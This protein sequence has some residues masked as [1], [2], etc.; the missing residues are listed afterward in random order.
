MR[1]ANFHHLHLLLWRPAAKADHHH[2]HLQQASYLLQVRV[3]SLVVLECPAQDQTLQGGAFAEN[4]P[5]GWKLQE[6][7]G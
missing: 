5:H 2:H 1:K 3:L 7:Q 6:F 4:I